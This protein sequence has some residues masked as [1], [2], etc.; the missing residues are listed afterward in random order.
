MVLFLLLEMHSYI[1][2]ESCDLTTIYVQPENITHDQQ[3]RRN[4]F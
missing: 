2:N 1:A 4:V 3:W